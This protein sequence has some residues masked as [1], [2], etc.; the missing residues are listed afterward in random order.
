MQPIKKITM[1]LTIELPDEL[2]A[3]I[4]RVT[5][6]QDIKEFVEKAIMDRLMV[7]QCTSQEQTVNS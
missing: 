1:Q 3:E 6:K 4:Q 7:E 2:V 5:G